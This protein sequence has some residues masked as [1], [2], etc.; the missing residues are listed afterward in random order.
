MAIG[1]SIASVAA[2]AADNPL[3]GFDGDPNQHWVDLLASAFDGLILLPFALLFVCG[4][5]RLNLNR[6]P[7]V[8]AALATVLALVVSGLT[9]E[10]IAPIFTDNNEMLEM[11]GL[12]RFQYMLLPGLLVCFVGTL[13]V[14]WWSRRPKPTEAFE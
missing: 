5:H 3:Y 6:W 13:A 8:T 10:F 12:D 1:T 9:H 2:G 7:L 4:I 11:I 14:A